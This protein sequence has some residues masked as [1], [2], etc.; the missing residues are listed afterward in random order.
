M[1]L[2]LL[3]MKSTFT[4]LRRNRLFLAAFVLMIIFCGLYFRATLAGLTAGNEFKAI[5]QSFHMLC[6]MVSLLGAIMIVSILYHHISARSLKM[7][8]TRPCKPETWLASALFTVFA[9]LLALHILL[10]LVIMIPFAHY[11]I[12][13]P[14]A[15]VYALIYNFF[16]AVLFISVVSI[17]ASLLH[18]VMVL[19]AFTL[20]NEETLYGI[21][22]LFT[23]VL[24]VKLAADSLITRLI[25][26][27]YYILPTYTLFHSEMAAFMN[28][29]DFYDL[30]FGYFFF[31]IIYSLTAALFFFMLA[32]ILLRRRRITC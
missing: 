20:F 31:S 29:M 3:N 30:S 25:D 5:L 11:G 28:S 22:S 15:M 18:P 13:M 7:V 1:E 6:D 16:T 26:L 21:K 9:A 12:T 4:F 24:G 32:A 10:F 17:F 23:D 2:V 19:I 14:W 8:F 27:I